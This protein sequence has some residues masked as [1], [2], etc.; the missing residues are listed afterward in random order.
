M[1]KSPCKA[2]QNKGDDYLYP[3]ME[4]GSAVKTYRMDNSRAK[5]PGYLVKELHMAERF[6]LKRSKKD[7]IQF[8]ESMLKEEIK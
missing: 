7:L 5:I 1:E 6:R 2:Y 4:K 8:V 3:F